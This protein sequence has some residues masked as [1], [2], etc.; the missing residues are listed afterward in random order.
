MHAV[1][2]VA[3]LLAATG[4][5]RSCT[6]GAGNYSNYPSRPCGCLPCLR[7]THQ[8]GEA[9]WSLEGMFTA[10]LV[11]EAGR[12]AMTEGSA[13][14]EECPRGTYAPEPGWGEECLECEVGGVPNANRTACA[15]CAAGTY[16]N[17]SATCAACPAGT[18]KPGTGG[19]LLDCAT[20]PSVRANDDG[21]ACLCSTDP[22]RVEHACPANWTCPEAGLPDRDVACVRDA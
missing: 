9:P 15:Q 18:F 10:C 5:A 13:V 20:C 17:A 2:L 6:C 21:T 8:P 11:C 14:C 22:A 7:G 16:W 1:L 3:A 12:H 19:T 4:E